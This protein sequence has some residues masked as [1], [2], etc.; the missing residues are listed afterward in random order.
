MVTGNETSIFPDQTEFQRRLS[1]EGRLNAA[2]T[3]PGTTFLVLGGGVTVEQ[4]MSGEEITRIFVD[5]EQYLRTYQADWAQWLTEAKAAWPS[6]ATDVI[7]TLKLWFEPLMAMATSVR[8]GIAGNCLINAGNLPIF[9]NFFDGTVELHAGQP[10][11]FRFD[12]PRDLVENVV[13]HRAVDWSNSLFLSCRF[14][15]WR[16]G[17][18]NEYLYNFFKS[19]SVERMTRTESEAKNKM[20]GIPS[21]ES[22]IVIGDY[23]V[24]RRCPHR[25]ADLSVFG[26]IDGDDLVCTLHGWRFDLETGT[27]RT[28][29]E[30]AI[31][32][33]KRS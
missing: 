1:D 21:D 14:T 29:T 18:Y 33:R 28:A 4:P 15:A 10:F 22:D 12:I 20:L 13:A 5:K 24:Q 3:I 17:E 6:P 31:R 30:K 27:C 16:E 19:L 23:E 8:Q 32:V 9:L 7:A 26:Q 2:T 11:S 25:N